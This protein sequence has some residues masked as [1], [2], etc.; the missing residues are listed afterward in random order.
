MTI[1]EIR[2]IV[3]VQRSAA[4]NDG[5]YAVGKAAVPRKGDHTDANAHRKPVQA[6]CKAGRRRCGGRRYRHVG[7]LRFGADTFV[8]FGHRYEDSPDEA[9]E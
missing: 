9:Q 2:R 4:Q 6:V 7:Q 3:G 1:R 5:A 8:R